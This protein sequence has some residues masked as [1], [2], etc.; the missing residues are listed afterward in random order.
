MMSGTRRSPSGVGMRLP[1]GAPFASSSGL[2]ELSQCRSDVCD[3]SR[4]LDAAEEALFQ[5]K[6][7]FRNSKGVGI[8]L[9]ARFR[10]SEGVGIVPLRARSCSVILKG[11]I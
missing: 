8:P 6:H 11:S 2:V 9:R 1:I 5:Q 4:G 3:L 10:D 7:V